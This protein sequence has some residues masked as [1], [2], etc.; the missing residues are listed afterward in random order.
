MPAVVHTLETGPND[1]PE[2]LMVGSIVGVQ[3]TRAP[4]PACPR[5]IA[6]PLNMPTALLSGVI[7][8]TVASMPA[9]AAKKKQ[10]PAYRADST[11]LDGRVTGYPRTCGYDTFLRDSRGV[12]MGPYCH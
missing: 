4:A 1:V 5:S 3:S 10:Q 12:P 9:D 7:V 8:A 11:S 6:M 2:A